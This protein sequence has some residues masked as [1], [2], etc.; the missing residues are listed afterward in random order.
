MSLNQIIIEPEL[1]IGTEFWIMKDNRPTLGLIAA[2]NVHVT[3]CID[4]NHGWHNQ[5]FMRWLT[6]KQKEVYTY[7]CSYEVKIDTTIIVF[8]I[9]KKNDTWWLHDRRVYFSLDELKASL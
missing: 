6:G 9:V 2:Y 7:S 5:L 8:G 4:K 3:S 1:P